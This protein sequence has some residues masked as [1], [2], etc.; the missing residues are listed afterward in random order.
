MNDQCNRPVTPSLAL[1]V[2]EIMQGLE[3]RRTQIEA[4]LR[5]ADG[6]H[7]YDDIVQ[8]VLQNRLVWWPLDNSSFML[9]EVISYPRQGHYHVFLAGGDLDTIRATQSDLINAA[10]LA[11]CSKLTLGGRRGWVKALHQL[12]WTEHCT[13]MGLDIPAEHDDGQRWKPEDDN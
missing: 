5:Y 4:A 7:T 8:M 2:I 13:V 1:A 3:A 10:K 6:T 11:G 12:G 9:T